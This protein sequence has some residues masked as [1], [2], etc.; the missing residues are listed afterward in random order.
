MSEQPKLTSISG[1]A[2]EGHMKQSETLQKLISEHT[3]Q[4]GKDEEMDDTRWQI[5]GESGE[6][7]GLLYYVVP[8]T[9]GASPEFIAKKIVQL[10]NESGSNVEVWSPRGEGKPW[11]PLSK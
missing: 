8:P 4:L 2:P 11:P 7:F 9:D 6:R 1:G 10:M 3:S 5:V